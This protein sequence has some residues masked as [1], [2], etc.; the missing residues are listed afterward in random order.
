M[1]DRK[2]LGI[3]ALALLAGL[4]MLVS[5]GEGDAT[6]NPDGDQIA[7][8]DEII[9]NEC[10]SQNDCAAGQACIPDGGVYKCLTVC[11]EDSDCQDVYPGGCCKA[12]GTSSFCQPIYNCSNEDGDTTVDGD[13]NQGCTADT[14]ECED[15][16]TVKRCKA[17]GTW[18]TYKKCT[19]DTC[20]S[21]G[22]CVAF[23][24]EVG[25]CELPDGCICTPDSYRCRGL[26]EVQK[27]PKSCDEWVWYRDCAEGSIC[28]NGK[29]SEAVEDG[30]DDPVVDGDEEIDEPEEC[31]PCDNGENSC[32]E[33]D[34]YCFIEDGKED[35]CCKRYCDL[36]GGNCPSG[37]EC[38]GGSCSPIVGYC[39]SDADC[40][41]MTHFCSKRLYTDENGNVAQ[42]KGGVCEEYCFNMGYMCPSN[43]YCDESE[44]S[45]N[46]GKCISMGDCTSCADDNQCATYPGLGPNYYCNKQEGQLTGCCIEKCSNTN[47]C[48]SG[49]QCCDGICG[50]NCGA[51]EC[52]KQC[53]TGEICD[54]LYDQCVLNCPPC[55]ATSCC[56]RNSAPNCVPGCVCENPIM[57]GLLLKPCCQGYSCSAFIYGVAGFC[58]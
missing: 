37:Y 14:Y 33:S 30:D 41:S 25:T 20:C 40:Q 31:V 26:K 17:D 32:E 18:I 8:G 52:T 48:P 19:E 22:Q 29:C 24:G 56:D 15:Y 44:I 13:T 6:S 5:C 51:M 50:V 10:T 16:N 47:P 1:S 12:I 21:G 43:T 53:G 58:I 9:G 39:I 11:E 35:G 49:L 3:F 28:V 34:E 55:D 7:D 46:Y 36:I 57:C 23:E 45:S 4:F 38:V 42:E 54:P 27:C 2:R